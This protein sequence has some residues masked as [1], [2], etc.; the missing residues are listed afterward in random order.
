IAPVQE[1]EFT[2]EPFVEGRPGPHVTAAV[3]AATLAGADV[4]FGP[5]ATTCR[6]A[7]DVMPDIVAGITRAAFA[8]GATHVMLHVTRVAE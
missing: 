7:D 2:V 3:E 4:D 1:I 5:F 8:N 6:A